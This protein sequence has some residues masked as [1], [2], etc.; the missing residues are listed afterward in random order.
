MFV[1]LNPEV[2]SYAESVSTLK[3]AERVSGVELGAACTNKKGKGIKELVEQVSILPCFMF[4]YG[5]DHF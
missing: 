5:F 3:F 2:K 1:Q 4:F